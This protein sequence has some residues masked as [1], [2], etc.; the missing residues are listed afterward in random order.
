MLDDLYVFLGIALSVLVLFVVFDEKELYN[1]VTLEIQNR[2]KKSLGRLEEKDHLQERMDALKDGLKKLEAKDAKAYEVKKTVTN[3]DAGNL[4]KS[5]DLKVQYRKCERKYNRIKTLTPRGDDKDDSSI[6][7]QAALYTALFIVS[8]IGLDTLFKI[9]ENAGTH[10][11]LLLTLES[12]TYFSIF[13]W[14][15]AGVFRAAFNEY[16]I[17]NPKT[18]DADSEANPANVKWW[19][20]ALYRYRDRMKI[21]TTPSS[22]IILICIIVAWVVLVCLCSKSA[23]GWFLGIATSYVFFA[24]GM[25]FLARENPR[26]GVP[27]LNM[28]GQIAM[29]LVFSMILGLGSCFF[30]TNYYPEALFTVKRL[31]LYIFFFVL[32][33]GFILPILLPLGYYHIMVYARR[34]S[35]L[36]NLKKGERMLMI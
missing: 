22:I 5:I 7:V 31:K 9:Y 6:S 35:L 14:L 17:R 15:C 25:G 27:Y 26:K 23:P 24:G 30:C 28:Y 36:Y 12:L 1:K 2:I 20:K 33:N 3:E 16:I 21:H 19:R 29:I 34:M 32:L 8:V 10:D 18:E 13:Y 4:E 11:F